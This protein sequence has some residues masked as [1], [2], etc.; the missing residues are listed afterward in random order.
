MKGDLHYNFRK[1]KALTHHL[2]TNLEI[3]SLEQRKQR[4]WPK[5][6][7]VFI[8]SKVANVTYAHEFFQTPTE[9]ERNNEIKC[10]YSKA[11]ISHWLFVT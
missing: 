1:T 8:S 5:Y 7:E 4:V 11:F 6:A 3:T 2:H 9:C 10:L